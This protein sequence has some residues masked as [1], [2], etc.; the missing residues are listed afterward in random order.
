MNWRSILALHAKKLNLSQM[1]CVAVSR[2]I[3]WMNSWSKSFEGV[4]N[5]GL[6]FLFSHYWCSLNIPT[7]GNE[8]K[9]I[10]IYL[11]MI[12]NLPGLGGTDTLSVSLGRV[13]C[14][15]QIFKIRTGWKLE[16]FTYI[17]IFFSPNVCCKIIWQTKI[18][19]LEQNL[20][21]TKSLLDWSLSHW[22]IENFLFKS[23][24]CCIR[25]CKSNLQ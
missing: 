21:Q 3:I 9:T 22:N 24:S 5:P 13:L 19:N 10:L 18:Y 2:N 25:M 8:L 23:S 17:Y 16:F 6:S 14:A 12:I 11:H 15:L 4:R 20:L 7:S 1:L